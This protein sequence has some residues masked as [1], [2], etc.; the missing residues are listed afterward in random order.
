[1]SLIRS[2]TS[3]RAVWSFAGHRSQS[4]RVPWWEV[5]GIGTP[6]RSSLGPWRT[7]AALELPAVPSPSCSEAS[8]A[9]ISWGGE[10]RAVLL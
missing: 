8:A 4:A 7:K 2:P 9:E 1:M 5:A 3:V 10:A 6:P